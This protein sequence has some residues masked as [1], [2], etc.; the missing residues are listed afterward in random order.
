MRYLS[1]VLLALTAAGCGSGGETSEGDGSGG[2]GGG[3]LGA[4]G[5]T[6]AGLGGS[7]A[8][9]GGGGPGTDPADPRLEARVW[10]LT[11]TQYNAEIQRFFPGAPEVDLPVGGS[12][13]G[14]SNIATAA[15]I[16]TGNATA[17]TAAASSIAS[18]VGT[19]GA[20]A[21]RCTTYASSECADTLLD[22]LLPE[23]YRRPVTTEERAEIRAVYDDNLAAYGP[24]WSFSAMLRSL[25]LSPHFLYR[26]EIGPAG[27]GIVQLDDFEIA[28]LL[29]FS[30]VD[31]G[32]D[33]LLL[34]D[35]VA[36]RLVDPAVREAQ[37]RRLMDSSTAVWQRFFWEWLKMST[38]QS[39]GNETGL[40]AGL[41]AELEQ[42]YKDFVER[43]VVTNRG[44]L[45]DLL[46]ST[47]TWGSQAVA[48]YYGVAHPGG[49][50][51]AF[52]L[53]PTQRGGL[54]TLGAWLVAHG[55]KGRDNVVRRG[56]GLFRDA[57]CIDIKPLNIDLQA[58]ERELV[59]ADATIKEIAAARAADATC[60][61]CHA[62][63]DPIGLAFES[64]GGDGR[65]Q[66]TY[67]DGKPV[68]S[69]VEWN[70][71]QY[72]SAAEISA[73][74]VQ[75]DRFQQCLVRRFGHFLMGAD[76]GAP[77]VARAP[78]AALDAFKA[79]GGSFEELLVA[80]VR[81]PSF[82]ERRK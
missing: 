39:Q 25:L 77:V 8:S 49:E 61:A 76:F 12:E 34:D 58:A 46:T 21:A 5:G 20:A 24:E 42:E 71:V 75:D 63:S 54:L 31:H 2:T 68:E 40:D 14:L 16:D 18:W 44:S 3:A 11:P 59:G 45:T 65:F 53:D 27:S 22:W 36:A 28:S 13:Y 55:K 74:I 19:Q 67:A 41:V 15:R 79:A 6:G 30:L 47:H 69:Q 23:A 33:Q 62:T 32:P 1:I 70:G 48:D 29:S 60:G 17:Y 66:T 81:D 9:N 82:I 80:I 10:R 72:N 57:M 26:T 64:F 7:S 51:A 50:A 52:D 38:L 78:A 37:A 56:M 4:N 43:I 73:A 35:A